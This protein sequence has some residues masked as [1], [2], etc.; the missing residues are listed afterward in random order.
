MDK[1]TRLHKSTAELKQL[2]EVLLCGGT[3]NHPRSP[4]TSRV[5]E[6]C[7]QWKSMI[8]NYTIVT[9][10]VKSDKSA[11]RLEATEKSPKTK[12]DMIWY[13]KS[14]SD[15]VGGERGREVFHSSRLIINCSPRTRSRSIGVFC[16][17]PKL[18]ILLLR[19]APLPEPTC[20]LLACWSSVT[21]P[22]IVI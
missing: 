11:A 4:L 3:H 20:N 1:G 10:E 17:C 22:P 12:D 14:K 7:K 6:M 21:F 2:A 8:T 9:E 5:D 16:K 15:L 18:R 13:A 19:P